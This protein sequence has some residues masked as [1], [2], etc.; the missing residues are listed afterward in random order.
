MTNTTSEPRQA[1]SALTALR[2]RWLVAT[3]MT[4]IGAGL[5]IGYASTR[6]T[7]Y[8]GETRL[9]IGHGEMSAL[10]IPGYP[11][12]SRD[13]ASNYARWVT[14]QGVAG[15]AAPDGVYSLI[16]SPLPDSSVIRVEAKAGSADLAVKGSEVAAQALVNEVN[17]VKA[18]NDPAKILAEITAN[19]QAL[20]RAQGATNGALGKYNRELASTVAT[21]DTIAAALDEYVKNDSTR[22]KLQVEQDGRLDRYRRLVS[23][24]STEAELL[25]VSA[26]RL[27][28]DDRSSR[29]QRYG[30]LGIGAGGLL[31]LLAATGLERRAATSGRGRRSAR[32]KESSVSGPADQSPA[33]G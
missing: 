13:L 15:V 27:S 3:L 5:G 28:G 30:L 12:A 21:P 14:D 9:G 22:A 4:L 20:S 32:S 23:T 31:A 6:P 26:P 24:R 16:A 25:Q 17:K 7:T 29:L 1:I 8:T 10:N 19:A 11:T 18:E 33:N 2:R